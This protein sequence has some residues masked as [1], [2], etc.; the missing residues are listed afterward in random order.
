VELEEDILNRAQHEF[1]LLR[2]RRTRIMRIYLFR[3]CALVEG[4]ETM[5]E[6]IA[7]GVVVVS[8]GVVWEVV[9]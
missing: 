8:A 2:I 7:C 1:N 9:A 3:S 6:V 5:E 4:Y